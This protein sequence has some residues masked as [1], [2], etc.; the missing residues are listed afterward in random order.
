MRTTKQ[1][2]KSPINGDTITAIMSRLEQYQTLAR[3]Y[4]S[5]DNFVVDRDYLSRKKSTT[6]DLPR[7][8]RSIDI[9]LTDESVAAAK[10]KGCSNNEAG[11][12]T[13]KH[14]AKSKPLLGGWRS[15][16]VTLDDL[17]PGV[18]ICKFEFESGWGKFY[19]D[20]HALY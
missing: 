12:I 16:K 5:V 1:K 20:H 15:V 9:H 10:F 17:V 7:R 8:L 14:Y 19:Y 18:E 2:L 3:R 11:L 13:A 6:A 4:V